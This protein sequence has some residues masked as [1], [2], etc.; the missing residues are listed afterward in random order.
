MKK[1]YLLFAILITQTFAYGQYFNVLHRPTDLNDNFD[2]KASIKTSDDGFVVVGAFYVGDD[3]FDQQ[4]V[5]VKYNSTGDTLWTKR[6]VYDTL[7]YFSDVAEAANGD[8]LAVGCVGFDWAT[9]DQKGGYAS[10]VRFDAFGNLLWSRKIGYTNSSENNLIHARKPKI[11]TIGNDAIVFNSLNKEPSFIDL[12]LARIDASGNTIWSNEIQYDALF[13]TDFFDNANGNQGVGSLLILNNGNIFISGELSER[14]GATVL[15]AAIVDPNGLVLDGSVTN[16]TAVASASAI[17]YMRVEDAFEM[18]NGNIILT[19]ISYDLA[20]V[21]YGNG[22]TAITLDASLDFVEGDNYS[23]QGGERWLIHENADGSRTCAAAANVIM[24][25]EALILTKTD[26]TGIPIHTTKYGIQ[27]EY[28]TG[29]DV[30]L[31]NNQIFIS[32]TTKGFDMTNRRKNHMLVVDSAGSAPGCWG[33]SMNLSHDTFNQTWTAFLPSTG[34]GF[35]NN[36]IVFAQGNFATFSEEVTINYTSVVNDATC[37]GEQGGINLTMAGSATYGFD[38]SNGTSAEDLAEFAGTYS[39]LINDGLGCEL[40]DT[41]EI[42]EPLELDASATSDNVSC[43]G[44]GDG[45]IDLTV[46]GGTPGYQFNWTNGA[47]VEDLNGLSGGFYQVEVSDANGCIDYLSVSVTEPPQL[48]AVILGYED[49]TCNGNCDGRL[50]G[51]A[52]G[53]RPPYVYEWNDPMLQVTDT[54]SGLCPGTYLFR[55]TDDNGCINFVNGFIAEP[56]VLLA[57]VNTTPTTCGDSIGTASADAMG[58]TTPY[59]YSWNSAPFASQDS[60]FGLGNGLGELQ[61]SDINGCL[62]N[63]SFAIGSYTQPVDICAITVDSTEKNLVIW[64]KPADSSLSGIKIYRNVG[65]AYSLVGFQPYDSISQYVDNDFG[66]N[67]NMTSYRYKISAIDTCGNESDLSAYHETIHVTASLGVGGEVNLI[68][69]DYEGFT[70]GQYEIWRDSTGNGDWETIGSVPSTNFTYTDFHVPSSASIK[71][72]IDVVLPQPCI[73]EKAISHNNT[74]SNRGTIQGPIGLA[75][76][77]RAGVRLFPNPAN[78]QITIALS[79]A[80]SHSMVEAFDVGGRKVMEKSLE[81]VINTISLTTLKPGVYFFRLYG[82]AGQV[83]HRII[84]Y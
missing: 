65:G 39:V 66:V 21:V 70:F 36:P 67:P 48:T 51:F 58:G 10:V 45:E 46:I 52:T 12:N 41:F 60:T 1:I 28:V 23:T 30:D 62:F 53:G 84:K 16:L 49:V 34:I 8:I 6:F 14:D 71:Y 75:N 57:S 69:D 76:Y 83:D 68:W 19:G 27:V 82:K 55:V 50:N 63:T 2:S 7:S 17:P 54:A 5:V 64:E 81:G 18:S 44:L 78:N 74:R 4:Q 26:A 35:P 15:Y 80:S 42:G 40:A 31:N 29:L 56:D 72:A 61:V 24:F 22:A 38:W 37:H 9:P 79:N 32:A 20:G 59:F 11:E 77:Q 73:A 43:F 25:S 3:E 13:S 47:T 33:S